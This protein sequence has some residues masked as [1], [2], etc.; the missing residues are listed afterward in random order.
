MKP[1]P[2]HL[3]DRCGRFIQAGGPH[4]AMALRLTSGF[5]GYLND[6]TTDESLGETLKNLED[7][8]VEQLEAQVELK[9]EFLLCPG[10]RNHIANDPLQKAFTTPDV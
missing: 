9:L 8:D 4:Y 5:D 3:C 2:H 10:C 1:A 7:T 6:P